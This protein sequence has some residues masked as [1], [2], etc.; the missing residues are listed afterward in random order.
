METLRKLKKRFSGV[1]KKEQKNTKPHYMLTK[2]QTANSLQHNQNKT[3]TGSNNE[4]YLDTVVDKTKAGIEST[5]EYLSNMT[6]SQEQIDREKPVGQKIG[7]SMEDAGNAI[8][9]SMPKSAADAGKSIGN[10]VDS[11]ATK[12]KDAMHDATK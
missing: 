7:E 11:G 1:L 9:E 3:M 4:S 12:V 2:N 5:K 10:A 6:K 8:K